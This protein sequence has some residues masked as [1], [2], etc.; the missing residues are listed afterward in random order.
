[1]KKSTLSAYR[2]HRN[3]IPCGLRRST[4]AGLALLSV[5]L[6]ASIS[7]AAV[8]SNVV[9]TG[10]D[11]EPTDTITAKWTGQTFPVSIAGEPILG[12]VVGSNFSVPA[13]G[14]NVPSF[15]DRAHRYM[16]D[17]GSATSAALPIP[18]YLVGGDYIM[19]GNDNRDNAGYSLSVSLLGAS[20][21]F[22]LIDNRL[23]DSLGTNPPV[24]DATHMQWI[25]TGGWLPTN[26]G[27]N[28]LGSTA[29]PDEVPFDEGG[30]GTINQYYS[31]YFKDFA[32]GNATLLQADNAGQNMYGVVGKAIPEPASAS[33]A[34][35]GLLA[36][37]GRRRRNAR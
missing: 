36:I 4:L 23:G 34:A 21:I 32:G 19:S 35:F 33:I 5:G 3:N 20:R 1:M 30:D 29:V 14:N 18:A 15:V 9:E 6:M 7:K 13:F 24:F 16:N 26:T 12:A 22:M 37:A 8:F 11:N 2:T 25:T 17:P 31:V 28:R 27:L 10:G